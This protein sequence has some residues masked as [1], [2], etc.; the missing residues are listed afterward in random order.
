L[1]VVA[2]AVI[3]AVGTAR[4]WVLITLLAAP[5]AVPPARTVLG[6]G[7]GPA[8][9]TALAGTGLLTLVTGILLGAGLTL[10]G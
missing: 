1:F 10:S 7:Q 5:L 6:G 3:V 8:L 4:P 2:F 9:I